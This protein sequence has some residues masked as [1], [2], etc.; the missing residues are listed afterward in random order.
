MKIVVAADVA[1]CE[2]LAG[3]VHKNALTSI[4]RFRG[5]F[6]HFKLKSFT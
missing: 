3:I 6:L 4:E 2:Q 1:V 5:K